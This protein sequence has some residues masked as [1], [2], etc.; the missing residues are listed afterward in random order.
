MKAGILIILV[1]IFMG[2][3]ISN[4][5][6]RLDIW[7]ANFKAW[8]LGFDIHE[9]FGFEIDLKLKCVPRYIGKIVNY[10]FFCIATLFITGSLFF[11]YKEQS[12]DLPLVAKL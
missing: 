9:V 4:F 12:K 7:D 2:F 8:G 11:S 5:I 10:S 1:G 6:L 3:G